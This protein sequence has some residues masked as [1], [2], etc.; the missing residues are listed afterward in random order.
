VGRFW[1][2]AGKRSILITVD[3]GLSSCMPSI[4]N[5]QGDPHPQVV[6]FMEN[7]NDSTLLCRAHIGTNIPPG[8]PGTLK[9][10]VSGK[11]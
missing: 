9:G 4:F 3:V 8:R 2:E 6:V 1:E 11:L 7:I 10:Q 5:Q